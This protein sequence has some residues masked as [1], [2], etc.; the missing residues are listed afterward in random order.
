[1]SGPCV[2]SPHVAAG[3]RAADRVP[4][5]AESS[6]VGLSG[7]G[8]AMDDP[9]GPL[10]SPCSC[11]SVRYWPTSL[12]AKLM[13]RRP[14]SSRRGN[15]STAQITYL[16]SRCLP[17]WSHRTNAVLRCHCPPSCRFVA[18]AMRDGPTRDRCFTTAARISPW[19]SSPTMALHDTLSL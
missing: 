10:S 1:M 7:H 9:S 3:H 2:W 6:L 18:P 5:S 13:S 17:P 4:R 11:W 15:R 12:P 19:P 8:L 14:S 16:L